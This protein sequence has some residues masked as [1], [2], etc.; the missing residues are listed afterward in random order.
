MFFYAN[1]RNSF[2]VTF[3]ND[4]VAYQCLSFIELVLGAGSLGVG[5]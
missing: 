5:S 2:T 3:T 4:V 1:I